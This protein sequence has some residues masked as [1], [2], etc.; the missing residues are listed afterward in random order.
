MLEQSPA[1]ALPAEDIKME[2]Y[3]MQSLAL[4]R[5]NRQAFSMHLEMDSTKS[6]QSLG[7]R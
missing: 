1:F 4:L 3:I 6:E 2:V 5:A 7:I